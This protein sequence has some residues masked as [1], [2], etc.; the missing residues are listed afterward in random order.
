KAGHHDRDFLDR[1]CSGA[2]QFLAYLAGAPDGVDKDAAWAEAI[3]EIE[4]GRIRNLAQALVATRSMLTVSWSLQRADHGEQPFWAA[5]GL[6]AITGQIGL[7]GGGVGY[8]YG[9]L[10]GVGAPFGIAKSPA[11][12]QLRKPIDSFIPVARITDLLLNPGG[13][14]DYEGQGYT[15]PDTRMVYWAGGNPFH[16]HQDLNRLADAW[17][18]PETIVVQDPMWTATAQRA[19]IVLPATTSIERHD[20]AGN[21]R[22][23]FLVAMHKAIEPVGAARSDFDIFNALAEKLGVAMAFNEGRDEMGWIRHLYEASRT[24]ARDRLGVQLPD[25]ET[26][27]RD[28]SARVPT[29]DNYTYLADF[30]ASPDEHPL[31]TESGRIVL[32]S[33]Q[34]TG[35]GYDDC[36][37]HPAWLPPAEWLGSDTA[38]DDQFHLIS[39]QPAGRL[40]SQLETAPAS[41]LHKRDG[42]ELVRINAAAAARLGVVDG[43]AVRLWNERGQCLAT[44]AISNDVRDRVAVLPTG[45]WFTPAAEGGLEL[46]GNPNVLTLD[47]PTSQFGQGCSA[48]TCLVRIEPYAGTSPDADLKYLHDIAILTSA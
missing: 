35:L 16:H 43:Q 26:F 48:H 31:A 8:G 22:S 42:R 7:P 47:K 33:T 40:H 5:L 11:M 21:R 12:S 44:L 2:D 20:I 36:L 41:R 30:R 39:H 34:L 24:D 32:T 29:Q 9:S 37:S 23:D 15:Y 4:A 19:D 27:W 3:T 17:T 28:G 10:G 45:S 46:S 25:F 38:G 13:A 6:A 18:R 14:F 1:C